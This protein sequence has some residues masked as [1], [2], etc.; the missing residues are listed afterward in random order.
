MSK[1][2]LWWLK[3]NL[4]LTEPQWSQRLCK[5]KTFRKT[6]TFR[7]VNYCIEFGLIG[8][9]LHWWTPVYHEGRGHYLS[10]GLGLIGL[11]KGY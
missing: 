8:F 4:W 5:H 2:M 9:W 6:V 1:A 7:R 11:F 3:L 10:C